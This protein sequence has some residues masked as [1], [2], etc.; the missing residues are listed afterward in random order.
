MGQESKWK[1]TLSRR[2]QHYGYT[3]NYRTLMIDYSKPT[4]PFP[5]RCSDVVQRITTSLSSSLIQDEEVEL[6]QLTINEY[7]PGQGIAGITI[8]ACVYMYNERLY[9]TYRH[10]SLLRTCHLH[11]LLKQVFIY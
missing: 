2:V 6:T 1:Q 3:F 9:S 10:S 8:D 5:Q 7:Y 4:D 11:S